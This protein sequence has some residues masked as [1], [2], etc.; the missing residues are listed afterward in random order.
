MDG[1]I[2][3]EHGM[4]RLRAPYLEAEWGPKA[5]RLFGVTKE[6]FDNQGVLNPDALFYR[7]EITAEMDL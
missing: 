4:G 5:C 1:T 2:T 7:G 6:L 3:A